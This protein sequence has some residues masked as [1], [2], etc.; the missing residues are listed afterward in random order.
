[1]ALAA[2]VTVLMAC[3]TDDGREMQPPDSYARFQLENT[4]T[5]TSTTVA[6]APTEFIPVTTLTT[7][8]TSSSSSTTTSSTAPSSS[9]G[10]TTQPGAS[11]SQAALNAVANPLQFAGPWAEGAA[12][13]V[14]FTCDGT[15]D[16]PLL[17][18]TAPPGG[19][20]ELAVSVIDPDADGF[21]H[22][23]VIGLPAEAGSVGGGEPVVTGA[24]E[25][26]NSFGN[27]GWGGPCPPPGDGP[28]TYQ[29]TLHLLDQAIEL[30]ADTPTNEL[31]TAVEAST[32]DR[33]TFTGTYERA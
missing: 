4:T 23:L 22:W 6:P 30:P 1:L 28:H 18:W 11:T 24:S 33:A 26:A 32:A 17:T 9:T 19:T 3:D 25:A 14:E 13:P 31:I 15:D 8:T 27:P 29:F 5:S 16:A 12:I 20:A 10:S 7:P 2:T 21:V